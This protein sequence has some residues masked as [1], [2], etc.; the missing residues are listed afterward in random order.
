MV[1]TQTATAP[2]SPRADAKPKRDGIPDLYYY[3]DTARL[4]TPFRDAAC[5][6]I[7][8]RAAETAAPGP[9]SAEVSAWN[10]PGEE[11]AWSLVLT[12]FLDTGW[13][14]VKKARGDI[15]N[16]MRR[17]SMDWSPSEKE[18]YRKRIHFEVFPS[19]P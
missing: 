1:Q 4:R 3:P 15:L 7:L 6:L 9:V 14:G 19:Q 12:V 10:H 18:D 11:D 17:I 5:R 8:L 13:D 16:Y 2:I